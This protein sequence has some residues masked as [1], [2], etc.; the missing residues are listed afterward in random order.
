LQRILQLE[1]DRLRWTG[2]FSEKVFH[3]ADNI[4]I[5]DRKRFLWSK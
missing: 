5:W 4:C 3:G 1:V 2:E